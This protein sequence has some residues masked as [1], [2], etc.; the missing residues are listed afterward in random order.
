M[1]FAL[2]PVAVLL[3]AAPALAEERDY[4][5]A[6]PGLGT[7]ACTIAPGRVSVEMGLADSTREED[8]SQRTDTILIGDTLVRIGL[9]QTIEVQLDAIRPCPHPRQDRP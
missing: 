6:R 5:P 4:C 3:T 8:S 9:T 2:M 7:P 1:R